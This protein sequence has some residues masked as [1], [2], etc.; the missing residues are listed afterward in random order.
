MPPGEMQMSEQEKLAAQGKAHAELKT[1]KSDVATLKTI[2][3]DDAKWLR[4]T[5]SY[6]SDLVRNP[7]A[8]TEVGPIHRE[9]SFDL[10]H[11]P[12]HSDIARRIAEL[13]MK[14]THMN[15]L[16]AQVDQF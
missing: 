4:D 8:Q 16:Q 1:L 6:V 14:T 10:S 15:D 12:A 2:L 3:I 5:A 7:L 13:A 9:L 11:G